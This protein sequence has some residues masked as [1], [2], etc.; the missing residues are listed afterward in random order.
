MDGDINADG[1]VTY[2]ELKETLQREMRAR[3]FSHTPQGLPPLSEDTQDLSNRPVFGSAAAP[4]VLAAAAT[5]IAS[6]STAT[7]S[8]KQEEDDKPGALTVNLEAG[9]TQF[10][11]ALTVLANVKVVKGNAALFLRKEA[12]QILFVS[13]AGDLILKLPGGKQQDIVSMVQHQAWVNSLVNL[14]YKNDFAVN[15]EFDMPGRGSAAVDGDDIGFTFKSATPSYLLL[16]DIDPQGNINVIY[17]YLANELLP[18]QANTTKSF[19]NLSEVTA[20]Y[21]RDF[22]QLYAFQDYSE[23][24]KLLMGKTIAKDSPLLAEFNALIADK[25]LRKSRS[26][27]ELVTSAAN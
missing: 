25:N 3:G 24:L 9:A 22:I 26:S 5:P 1:T 17:P 6:Q 11:A 27:L 16:V 13:G 12:N 20:P 4:I 23:K 7:D 14:P 15:L 21:G 8:K 19:P 2:A 18:I 10:A